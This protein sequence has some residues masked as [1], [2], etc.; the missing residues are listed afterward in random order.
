MAE[1]NDPGGMHPERLGMIGPN[2]DEPRPCRLESTRLFR[3]ECS[4]RRRGK[5]DDNRRLSCPGTD[6]FIVD[7]RQTDAKIRIRAGRVNPLSFFF[8]ALDASGRAGL[9]PRATPRH[10]ARSRSFCRRAGARTPVVIASAVI[11]CQTRYSH[12]QDPATT[13]RKIA[14]LG[15]RIASFNRRTLSPSSGRRIRACW[16]GD[17][18]G[19]SE[20]VGCAAGRAPMF[21]VAEH[22]R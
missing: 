13:T 12:W 19:E 6:P 9:L 3:Q 2:R 17:R 1:E 8:P 14:S 18:P 4:E 15:C 10:S 7:W 5:L 16:P 11:P 21:D 20:W 22:G